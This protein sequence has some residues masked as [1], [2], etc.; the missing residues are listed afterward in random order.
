VATLSTN[1]K[2]RLANFRTRC[3]YTRRCVCSPHVS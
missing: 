2:D 1:F 3:I